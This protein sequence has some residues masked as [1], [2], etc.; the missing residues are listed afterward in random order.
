MR[1]ALLALAAAG[2]AHGSSHVR[3]PQGRPLPTTAILDADSNG[4][5]LECLDG[6][7]YVIVEPP[8][9]YLAGT[10]LVTQRVL[11]TDAPRL[12]EQIRDAD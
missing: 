11:I 1:I 8:R 9:P 6:R 5:N 7:H 3:D 4:A 12:C 2:C 10:H